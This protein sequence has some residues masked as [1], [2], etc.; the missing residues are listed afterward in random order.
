MG[1]LAVLFAVAFAYQVVV[2]LGHDIGALA[3]QPSFAEG[4][5]LGVPYLLASHFFEHVLDSLFFTLVTL[6]LVWGCRSVPSGAEAGRGR[7]PHS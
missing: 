7:A 6:L 5:R 4:G 1:A 3:Q 2:S